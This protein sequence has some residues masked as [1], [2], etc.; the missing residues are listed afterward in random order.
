MVRS[1]ADRTFQPRP[2]PPDAAGA[3]AGDASFREAEDAKTWSRVEVRD[4]AVPGAGLG[5]FATAPAECGEVAGLSGRW[6]R[7]SAAACANE[8]AALL[9]EFQKSSKLPPC[10]AAA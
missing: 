1:L 8:E 3:A 4:S 10:G 5:L 6:R 9:A 7:P 2:A